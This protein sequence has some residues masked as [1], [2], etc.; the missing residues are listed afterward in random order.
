MRK[1]I[2]TCIVALS[3]ITATKAQKEVTINIQKSL[4]N[5]KGSMLFGFGEHYG[6]TK[7]KKGKI[8]L[9][10]DKITGGTF[11]IDMNSIVNTDGKYNESL[12][13]H[14]KNQDFFHVE[15]YPT[16]SLTITE[17]EYQPNQKD[18]A[19]KSDLT[20]KG[21]TH[22]VNYYGEIDMDKKMMKARLVIDRTQ[23]NIN[24]GSRGITNVRDLIISEAIKFEV[25]LHWK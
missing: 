18:L 23:W 5:W 10:N 7:F 20:I 2:F 14:L 17:I 12:V 13:D 8:I 22:P 19:I 3:F 15:K 4:V 24:Y 25:V 1:I 11:V 9:E 6:T 21:I 16:T